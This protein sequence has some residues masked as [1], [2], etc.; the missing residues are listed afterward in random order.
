MVRNGAGP[1]ISSSDKRIL[2]LCLFSALHTCLSLVAAAQTSPLSLSRRGTSSRG[3]V[4]RRLTSAEQPFFPE[5][6]EEA[7]FVTVTVVQESPD[8]RVGNVGNEKGDFGETVVEQS[9]FGFSAHKTARAIA[10]TTQYQRKTSSG[11]NRLYTQL[12][13]VISLKSAKHNLVPATSIYTKPEQHQTKS[14]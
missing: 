10:R 5:A 1:F 9:V 3:L 12:P 13:E 14:F 6:K 8:E 2:T 11:E 4:L 7:Y